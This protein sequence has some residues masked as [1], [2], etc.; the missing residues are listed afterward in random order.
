MR[1][2]PCG[3]GRPPAGRSSP[4]HA[5][6][7][8]CR[9]TGSGLRAVAAT[10]ESPARART[11]QAGSPRARRS[12][13]AYWVTPKRERAASVSVGCRQ[14][15]G[16]DEQARVL[17]PRR[18]DTVEETVVPM[19]SALSSARRGEASAIKSPVHS[20][21]CEGSEPEKAAAGV[22]R[23]RLCTTPAAHQG[24]RIIRRGLQGVSTRTRRA[25]STGP[26]A[27]PLR[28]G[29]PCPQGAAAGPARIPCGAR[30]RQLRSHRA[31]CAVAPGAD[32]DGIAHDG[33][34]VSRVLDLQGDALDLPPSTVDV[35]A[36]PD[37][38]KS[39][40]RGE[41]PGPSPGVGRGSTGLMTG[42]G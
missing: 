12:D 18:L 33:V 5:D 29:R 9:N 7:V 30:S 24:I 28:T 40:H 23:R 3:R 34:R 8:C 15:G 4:L 19:S 27:P 17:R 16:R 37:A 39:A 1:A 14:V 10:D 38:R 42:P 6:V 26:A 41:G 35:E 11:P 13:P 32:L 22:R 31:G 21:R 2:S 20:G 25:V 36:Q